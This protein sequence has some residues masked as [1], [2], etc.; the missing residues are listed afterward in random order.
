MARTPVLHGQLQSSGGLHGQ[1]SA[2]NDAARDMAFDGVQGVFQLRDPRRARYHGEPASGA[3]VA[4]LGRGANSATI[5][6]QSSLDLDEV[7]EL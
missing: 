3:Y 1:V 6:G 7:L 5:D 4:N 2:G